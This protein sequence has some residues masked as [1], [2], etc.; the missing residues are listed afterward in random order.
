MDGFPRSICLVSDDLDLSNT[1]SIAS[2]QINQE[3]CRVQ[4]LIASI[5]SIDQATRL[6]LHDAGNQGCFSKGFPR[7]SLYHYSEL[8]RQSNPATQRTDS[9]CPGRLTPAHPFDLI[10]FPERGALGFRTVQARRAGLCLT[11]V[12]LAVQLV[13]PSWWLRA[14][15]RK[16]LEYKEDLRNDFAEQFAFEHADL[17]L[18]S[19][20]SLADE[21][22]AG[23]WAVRDDVMVTDNV[24]PDGYSRTIP[25]PIEPDRDAPLVSVV[26]THYNLGA[27]LPDALA[28]LAASNLSQSRS[29]RGG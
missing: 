24:V 23:G 4:L 5:T 29:P 7:W 13:G 1:V 25:H 15:E 14:K 11:D 22:R 2:R 6:K 19:S 3:S 18:A 21:V 12:L 17:Q 20:R 16:G 9:P 26:V 8:R 28:S 27:Y 10:L